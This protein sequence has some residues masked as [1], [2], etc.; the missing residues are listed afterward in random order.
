MQQL[1]LLINRC[2]RGSETMCVIG[3]LNKIVPLSRNLITNNKV[4]TRILSNKQAY[5]VFYMLYCISAVKKTKRWT[6]LRRGQE[7]IRLNLHIV[8]Y[9][10]FT[11]YKMYRLS[12]TCASVLS[13]IMRNVVLALGGFSDYYLWSD[14][15]IE[16]KNRDPPVHYFLRHLKSNNNWI[17]V[18]VTLNVSNRRHK[19]RC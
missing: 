3:K 13:H 15:F 5:F 12:V 19:K 9:H 17:S 16:A 8:P 7:K 14:I 1:S 11:P 10:K 2:V 4:P 6:L 18:Y